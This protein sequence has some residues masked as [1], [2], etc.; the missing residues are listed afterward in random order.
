[1]TLPR[2][3]R[4]EWRPTSTDSAALMT[5]SGALTSADYVPGQQ[6]IV[7]FALHATA[8]LL[9]MAH[10]DPDVCAALDAVRKSIPNIPNGARA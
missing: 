4:V 6:T 2:P 7:R 1:M 5:I 10:R 3:P 9:A 8:R